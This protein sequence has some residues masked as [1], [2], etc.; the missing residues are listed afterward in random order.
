[1]T[2]VDAIMERLGGMTRGEAND[3]LVG[4]IDVLAEA[5]GFEAADDVTGFGTIGDALIVAIGMLADDDVKRD[6]VLRAID[7]ETSD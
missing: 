6:A 7:E 5:N 4:C 1:M 2:L 3:V